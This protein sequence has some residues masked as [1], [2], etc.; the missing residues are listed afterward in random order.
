[1]VPPQPYSGSP[2]WPPVTTILY[3]RAGLADCAAALWVALAVARL[4][5]FRISRR[6][7]MGGSVEFS[8]MVGV[9]ERA[10]DLAS[11]ATLLRMLDHAIMS[12]VAEQMMRGSEVVV[13][14]RKSD[15]T[16]TGALRL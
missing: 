11:G 15:V 8:V 2:G 9:W 4:I 13:E 16:R 5:A 3:L 10:G 12:S 14:G 7:I 6:F 1:M